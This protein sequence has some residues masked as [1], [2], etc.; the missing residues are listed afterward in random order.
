V[1]LRVTPGSP[2]LSLVTYTPRGIVGIKIAKWKGNRM[3]AIETIV[4]LPSTEAEV[5][6]RE[7]PATQGFGVLGEI[8][9]AAALEARLGGDRSPLKILGACNPSLGDRALK[10]GPG[11]TFVPA[12]PSAVRTRIAASAPSQHGSWQ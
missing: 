2:V 8:D 3:R 1:T 7:A 9:V 4:D 5:A 12:V 6:V 10:I 11:S